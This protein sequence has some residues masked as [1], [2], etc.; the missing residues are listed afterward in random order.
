[1]PVSSTSSHF[2]IFLKWEAA[3]IA[4]KMQQDG[5]TSS[6]HLVWRFASWLWERVPEG[7]LA[8]PESSPSLAQILTEDS[9]IWH[10]GKDLPL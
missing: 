2:D 8:D 1:M 5:L 4:D 6:Q 7:V 3:F 10:A 9:S